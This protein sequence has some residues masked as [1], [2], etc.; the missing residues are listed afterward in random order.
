M[1]LEDAAAPPIPVID[2]LPRHVAIIMDGNGRWAKLRGLSR[3]EGHR[4]GARN[5]RTVIE[6]LS[7]HGV[8]MLTLFAFSTENWGRPRGE[9][10][11]IMPSGPGVH[12]PASG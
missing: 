8:P 12:R 10:R 6:R 7:G 4:A 11:A 9:V 2:P 1:A 3:T 5:I